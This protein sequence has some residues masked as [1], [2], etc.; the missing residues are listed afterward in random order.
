MSEHIGE[1]VATVEQQQGLAVAHELYD[2]YVRALEADHWGEFMAVTPD[3]RLLLGG[4]VSEV[5]HLLLE[6]VGPGS[7]SHIFKGGP[8]VV[9]RWR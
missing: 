5:V 7:G 8:L 1:S 6:A 3:R 2:R 4:S 9:G